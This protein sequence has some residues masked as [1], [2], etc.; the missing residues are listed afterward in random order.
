MVKVVFWFSSINSMLLGG[1]TLFFLYRYIWFSK[2]TIPA[3]RV[4]FAVLSLFFSL[5]V[6]FISTEVMRYRK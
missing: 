1:T 4:Q 2:E 5:I 6:V 3:E